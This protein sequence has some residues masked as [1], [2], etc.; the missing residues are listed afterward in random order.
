[1]RPESATT[2][3]PGARAARNGALIAGILLLAFNLRPAITSLTPLF[4]DLATHDRLS[5]AELSLL[6]TLPVL[7]FGVFSAVAAPLA[8]RLGEERVLGGALV[9][10]ACGLVGRAALGSAALFPATV[11]GAA[12]IAVMNVLL[13]GLIKRRLAHLAGLLMGLYLLSL[14]V[15]ATLGSATAVPLYHGTGSWFIVLGVWTLPALIALIAWLP[16]TRERAPVRSTA[17]GP[18]ATNP[19]R[20]RLAWQ[21]AGFM[22]LQSLTYY[23]TLS[24]LPT[25]FRDRGSSPAQAGLLVSMLS[26]TGLVTAM[27]TPMVAHRRRDHRLLIVPSVLVCGIGIAGA[28]LAPLGTAVIWTGLLGLGQGAAL[29]LALYF[30]IARASTPR[31][32]VRLSAMA[33][34]VGYLLAA[35]GPLT[36]GLLY[37]STGGW[38]VPFSLLLVL[39]GIELVVGLFAARDRLLPEAPQEAGSPGE[40]TDPVGPGEATAPVEPPAS[41]VSV[42][43]GANGAADGAR[44]EPAAPE[45]PIGAGE[46]G[47]R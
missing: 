5:S 15:G 3:R 31:T 39:T 24:W 1:M 26:I 41:G 21:V 35:T 47:S 9:L 13:S 11:I 20:V 32:A 14:Y 8:R 19:Y 4:P 37:H 17:D 10:L 33:Q 29:G 12:A 40:A 38:A 34:C 27:L 25:L 42:A 23:A 2:G 43:A 45:A 16:Q 28:W 30:T 18:R 7:S 22:G 44:I 46:P 36:V 6:A